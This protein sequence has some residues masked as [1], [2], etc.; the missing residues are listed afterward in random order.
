VHGLR[1]WF[2]SDSEGAERRASPERGA[3]LGAVG[4]KT[5]SHERHE[6]HEGGIQMTGKQIYRAV[7]FTVG[8]AAVCFLLSNG[9]D[10]PATIV[11]TITAIVIT[12]GD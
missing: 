7:I 2:R 10:L 12:D 3:E 6:G 4:R 9:N 1:A 8:V 11:G 5:G